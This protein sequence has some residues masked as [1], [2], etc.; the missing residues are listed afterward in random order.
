LRS[1]ELGHRDVECTGE[2]FDDIEPDVDCG[3]SLDP[4][5]CGS[6]DSGAF[7]KGFLRKPE[8]CPS[9]DDIAT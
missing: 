5:D 3:S 6:R 8:S 2:S 9:D 4:R 7:S 1:E